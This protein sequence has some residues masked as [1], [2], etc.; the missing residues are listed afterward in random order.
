MSMHKRLRRFVETFGTST[1]HQALRVRYILVEADT[2]CNV[3][4]DS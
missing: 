4:I 3:L 1:K 2:S